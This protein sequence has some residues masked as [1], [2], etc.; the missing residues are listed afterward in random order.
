[1][2]L[3]IALEMQTLKILACEIYIYNPEP[4]NVL[5]WH[6]LHFWIWIKYI[7]HDLYWMHLN[8]SSE[9]HICYSLGRHVFEVIYMLQKS[10]RSSSLIWNSLRLLVSHYMY[11]WAAGFCGQIWSTHF[12]LVHATIWRNG[13]QPKHLINSELRWPCLCFATS[14]CWT[15]WQS[16]D[17]CTCTLDQVHAPSHLLKITPNLIFTIFSLSILLHPIWRQAIDA[18]KKIYIW[19]QIQLGWQNLPHRTNLRQLTSKQ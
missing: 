19:E 7:F 15:Q 12:K 17:K 13:F 1:M 8:F 10:Q 18:W 3:T 4:P 16:E 5:P 2:V 6:H 14:K 11:L 9:F